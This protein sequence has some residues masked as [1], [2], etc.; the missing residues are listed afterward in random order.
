MISADA[1]KGGG[2]MSFGCSQKITQKPVG[3]HVLRV[4]LKIAQT[5]FL[6]VCR[7]CFLLLCYISQIATGVPYSESPRKKTQIAPILIKIGRNLTCFGPVHSFDILILK[8]RKVG[9]AC[10]QG[11]FKNCKKIRDA[12]P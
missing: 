6:C 4:L 10:P 1:K 9:V 11:A 8:K 12:C 2:R 7:W 5:M 3:V